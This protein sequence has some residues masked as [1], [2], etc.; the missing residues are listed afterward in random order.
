[1][2][3][4]LFSPTPKFLVRETCPIFH[5]FHVVELF[6]KFKIQKVA[7]DPSAISYNNLL[8][9]IVKKEIQENEEQREKVLEKGVVKLEEVKKERVDVEDA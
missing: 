1:M 5:T 8:A 4:L 6:P 3:S 7:E 9:T 2:Y